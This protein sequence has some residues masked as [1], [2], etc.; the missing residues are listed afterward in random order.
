MLNDYL[1]YDITS[2]SKKRLRKKSRST[3]KQYD[4]SEEKFV[5]CIKWC[6]VWCSLLDQI[7]LTSTTEMK[8]KHSNLISS[9]YFKSLKFRIFKE[10]YYYIEKRIPFA[11]DKSW[12]C[13]ESF[14]RV[15]HDLL[16]LSSLCQNLQKQITC[17]CKQ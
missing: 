14:V 16:F 5:E 17:I 8:I 1:S 7:V 2:T 4:N 12:K 15:Y 3:K 10:Q 9:R 13:H 11:G 6:S